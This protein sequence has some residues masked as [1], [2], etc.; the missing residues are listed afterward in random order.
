MSP[1]IFNDKQSPFLQ[2]ANNLL[3]DVDVALAQ[4]D[5]QRTNTTRS[6]V[7]CIIEG[8]GSLVLLALTVL[9]FVFS[10]KIKVPVSPP[11]PLVVVADKLPK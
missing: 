11:T 9:A 2:R 7:F 6:I 4:R 1:P 3:N 5:I 8:I 10:F